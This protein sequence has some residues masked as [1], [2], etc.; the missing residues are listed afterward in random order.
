MLDPRLQ[1]SINEAVALVWSHI[2]HH[3]ARQASGGN[4]CNTPLCPC[5]DPAGLILAPAAPVP[6]PVEQPAARREG[7]A[8]SSR[9][10]LEAQQ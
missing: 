6:S 4:G 10:P 3:F 8:A 2:R 7:A 5:H 1:P 9:Y